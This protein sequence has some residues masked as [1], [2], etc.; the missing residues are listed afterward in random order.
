MLFIWV[1][2]LFIAPI[3]PAMIASSKGAYFIVWYIYGFIFYLIMPL[4]WFIPFT[5]ALIK[6][7]DEASGMIVGK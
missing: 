3:I 5:H 6:S 4:L 1:V 2:F 7:K